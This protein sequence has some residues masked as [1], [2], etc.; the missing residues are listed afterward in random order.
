MEGRAEVQTLQ[1]TRVGFTISAGASLPRDL[2]EANSSEISLRL[3]TF[4]PSVSAANPKDVPKHNTA[5]YGQLL[6]F[7]HLRCMSLPTD[8][9]IAGTEAWLEMAGDYF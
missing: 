4:Y 7:K 9:A 6:S 5:A 8:T 2:Q 1:W 3:H